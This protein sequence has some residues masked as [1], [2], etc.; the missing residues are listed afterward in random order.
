MNM[1][2]EHLYFV[3]SSSAD[4]TATGHG[5]EC[6]EYRDLQMHICHPDN[7]WFWKWQGWYYSLVFGPIPKGTATHINY[8]EAIRTIQ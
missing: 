3:S 2:T 4:A 8:F 1:A 6:G 5:V 7:F